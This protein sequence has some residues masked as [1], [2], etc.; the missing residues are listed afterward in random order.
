MSASNPEDHLDEPSKYA[1]KWFR[2]G[3]AKPRMGDLRRLPNAPQLVVSDTEPPSG[4][5]RRNNDIPFEGDL[6]IKRMRMQR[7]LEPERVTEPEWSEA[8]RFPLGMII[9]AAVA[10]GVATVGA[11]AY[12][13]ELP[14][15]FARAPQ[16]AAVRE[17]IG[18]DLRSPPQREAARAPKMG[19]RVG[20]VR[21]P[22]PAAPEAPAARIEAAPKA[23]A[24]PPR[25]AQQQV[26]LASTGT[27]PW[28]A[29]PAAIAPITRHLEPEEID[30]LIKRGEAFISQ[31][32]I[33]A[34]RLMLRRAAEAGNP[35]AALSL[36][37]TYDPDMLRKMGVLGF[38]PD[39]A[40]ARQWYEKAAAMGS[41]EASRRLAVLQ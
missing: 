6:A 34:A 15:P 16:E 7:S 19:E 37:A 11:L 33:S 25:P 22:A 1:P 21:A 14:N 38:Q 3:Q 17:T 4:T 31:G 28:P 2:D 8:P 39:I 30:T 35:R 27:S 41:G 32:D 10:I 24:E 26:A 9:R 20:E 36:G 18:A 40:Q 12:V 23:A 5:P 13:G 29:A